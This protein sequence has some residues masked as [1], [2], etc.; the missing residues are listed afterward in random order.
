[1]K[2]LATMA[3]TAV[4]ASAMS[5]SA[6]TISDITGTWTSVSGGTSVNGVGTNEVR[7]GTPGPS[8]IGLQS[9]LRFDGA[10]PPDVVVP[11]GVPFSLGD[12]SHFNEPLNAGTSA[13]GADLAVDVTF[14]DPA[15]VMT[16]FTFTF[17]INETPNAP[18]P[19][20][21]DDIIGFPDSFP[22]ETFQS[23]GVTYT[24]EL[25]GFGPTPDNIL[26]EFSSPEGGTNSTMLWARIVRTPDGGSTLILLGLACGLLRFG[27]KLRR[28]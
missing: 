11:E 9:G 20:A 18:G 6:F 8:G 14:S 17:S 15:G 19:P 7:W 27:S 4:A 28:K 12:L 10:A 1:M 3:I 21:S 16:P 13:N 2:K 26:P 25:L 5:A 24:L 23:G 22:D